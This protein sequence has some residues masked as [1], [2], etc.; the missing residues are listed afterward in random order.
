MKL[1]PQQ[2]ARLETFLTDYEEGATQIA[3]MSEYQ[4]NNAHSVSTTI[5]VL[6][7]IGIETRKGRRKKLN[8]SEHREYLAWLRER[9]KTG[10]TR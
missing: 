2:I 1:T 3:L 4:L 8:S 5:C 10:D 7:A 6:R 9:R